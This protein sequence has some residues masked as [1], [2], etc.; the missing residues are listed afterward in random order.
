MAHP[1]CLIIGGTG[2]VGSTIAKA[3][4][5]RGWNVTAIGRET[6]E[7]VKGWQFDF[8][9]NANG[10]ASRFRANQDPQ[11]DFEASVLSVYRSLFDFR[12]DVYGLIS[13]VDVYNEPSCEESTAEDTWIDT[14]TLAP[15]GMHKRLAE[16]LVMQHC[17]RWHVFRLAQMVGDGLKKGPIYDLLHRKPLWITADS[18]L[19]YMNTQNVARVV[20]NVMECQAASNIYN[21]CGRGNVEFRQVIELLAAGPSSVAPSPGERQT[22]RIQ[23]NK[24]E[25]LYAMPDSWD[26]VSTFVDHAL[27]GTDQVG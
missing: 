11:F 8:V 20:L 16:L 21:V 19:H 1:S 27:R 4:V 15:Y 23:T 10:N 5:E 14:E 25:Q 13:T 22:Y 24:I 2:F 7:R 26:E 18:R 3:A 12:Y 17:P 6:Y 9:I